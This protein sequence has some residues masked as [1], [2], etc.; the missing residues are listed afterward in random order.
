MNHPL[1]LTAVPQATD[2]HDPFSGPELAARLPLTEAQ[3]EIW[4]A[5][6][7]LEPVPMTAYNEAG[8]L[9]LRGPLDVPL[10]LSCLQTLVD[11]HE[12]LRGSF[13]SD[14]AWMMIRAHL[15]VDVPVI[16]ISADPERLRAQHEF[17]ATNDGFDLE[18]GPLIRWTL[19]RESD[20][21][22]HLVRSAHHIVVDGWSSW[23]LSNEL[24]KLYSAGREH[25]DAAL[26]EAPRYGDYAQLERDFVAS[27]EG[28]AHLDY[29]LNLLRDPPPVAEIPHSLPRPRERGYSARRLDQS[30]GAALA[31]RLRKQ[32]AAHG[33]SLVATL[34]AGFAATVHRQ[35]G[36]TDIVI[37]LAAAGQAFHQQNGLVGNA[38]NLLPLRLR[39]TGDM[40]FVELLRQARSAVL[41][42]FD[43]QGVSFGTVLPELK[44]TRDPT[45]PPLIT[46]LF[47]ID[48]RS[49]DVLFS[50]LS[51]EYRVLER[52]QE[53]FELF[54][55]I[56][57]DG[58]DLV[59][60][61]SYNAGLF[62][63]GD[64]ERMLNSWKALITDACAVP[65][66]K[67][68][69]L[70][71]MSPEARA[72]T[73]RG[74]NDTHRDYD[75][76]QPLHQL[77]EQ[78][79]K[80]SPDAPAL[81]SGDATL[82]YAQL[83]AEANRLAHLLVSR[84]VVR[85]QIVAVCAHRSVEM[86]VALLA[87]LK[88]GG[89]YL[90]LDP[91][92]PSD[93]LE[94]MLEDSAAKV[95]LVHTAGGADDDPGLPSVL[96]RHADK[97]IAL[98]ADAATWAGLPAQ[99]PQIGVGPDNLAYV[100]FTSG[101]TGK[102]KGAML[103]HR[104]IVNRLLWMQEEYRIGVGDKILQKTPYS[105]DVSVWEFFWPLMTGAT[106]VMARPDGHKDPR[107]LIDLITAQNIT[108]C[109]FVP[110]M[111]AIFLEDPD[112][113]RCGVLRKVFCSGE[114][115]SYEITQRFYSRLPSSELHNLYGPTEASVDVTYWA[116]PKTE[117][118]GIVPIGR[119]VAN[120]QLYV[121]DP[122]GEPLP[123]G[124]PGELM[125]GGV[126]L[127]RG[128]LN[129]PELTAEKFIT[130]REFG[131]LY[132]T[133]DL[134]RWLPDGNVEYLG[135]LDF[136]VKLHGFRIELGEIEA[137]LSSHPG[138]IE[139]AAGVVE[140]RPGD[141]R[142]AAWIVAR[143]EPPSAAELREHLR[144]TLPPHM[145]PNVFKVMERLPLLS[146]GKMDRKALPSPF[147]DAGFQVQQ[148]VQPSTP[149][150]LGLRDLWAELLGITDIGVDDRFLDIGGH[151]LLAM[152]MATRIQKKFGV[153]V[154]LR[155]IMMESLGAIAGALGEAPALVA[156]APSNATATPAAPTSTAAS[157]WPSRPAG[158]GARRDAGI[159]SRLKG[160]LGL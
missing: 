50:G 24:G 26:P 155:S 47:N 145:V 137:A 122:A 40:P 92:Y 100:I 53:V 152:Q 36:A 55:N 11:R 87:T 68:S 96:S 84:G 93:R 13:S 120:T 19:L 160:W 75:L 123:A 88:A 116:C 86:V 89:A 21:V 154:P 118:R 111:L 49:G 54:V 113:A 71:L 130:H 16:D 32:G 124:V 135:R 27:D 58:R 63:R 159:W 30:L 147:V 20:T 28:R 10:L 141:Q 73:I 104:G 103:E 57:D 1:E 128:Y 91:A 157:E 97:V 144:R 44:L 114:A 18:N 9:T 22:H 158:S 42:A 134:S 39:P 37:G 109:H 129:R 156:S 107:Y 76:S 61:A 136:Q 51:P 3:R 23:L 119:P 133:G 146:N 6:K 48:V 143:A 14:G 69:E 121:L 81:V 108:V 139:A 110:S 34:L 105:F 8:T 65:D 90:P 7:L 60:E 33:A 83:D 62:D 127:A 52:H 132:R 38:V 131:R 95:I 101:S 140:R 126:Q 102:P 125:L 99:P 15:P 149:A 142:L 74:W 79:V 85:D 106:L 70:S 59:T 150:Q 78:Q 43:H 115:L 45:R 138:V 64:I 5:C 77:I 35:S 56:V 17:A 67:L 2:Q 148:K 4:L 94:F 31:S 98:K 151:S 80:R 112:S 41:D 72:Q 25:R 12:A 117:R 29:W 66:R 82:S 46:A 153:K